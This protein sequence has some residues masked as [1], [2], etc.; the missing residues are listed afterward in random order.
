[1]VLEQWRL[2]VTL[3]EAVRWHHHAFDEVDGRVAR[4]VLVGE[5]LADLEERSVHG[6]AV[7]PTE[8][9]MALPA[10]MVERIRIEMRSEMDR[11]TSLF[12]GQH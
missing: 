6:P 12:G 7:E 4:F 5:A 10:P 8:A 11:I 1:M 9:L 3:V 2:P